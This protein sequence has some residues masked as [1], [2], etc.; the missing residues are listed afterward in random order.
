V[1]TK[2]IASDFSVAV[3]QP[4]VNP[5]QKWDRS[6][7]AE[8]IALMDSLTV[9]AMASQPNLVLWPESALPVYLRTSPVRKQIQAHVKKIKY[10]YY[11][12][13]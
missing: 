5:V 13:L 7:R 3:I 12:G 8:L 9:E 6:F 4:N 1:E 10:Q 11:P 2:S